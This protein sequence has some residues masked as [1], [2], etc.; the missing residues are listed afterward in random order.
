MQIAVQLR[1]ETRDD[2]AAML[3]GA[4]ILGNQCARK[5]DAGTTAFNAQRERRRHSLRER[6]F[7][8]AVQHSFGLFMNNRVSGILTGRAG[9]VSDH[10]RQVGNGDARK[11]APDKA[12]AGS[13][14]PLHACCP[15]ILWIKV[16]IL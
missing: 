10:V 6:I 7:L 11:P 4:V 12:S 8:A 5:F 3:A 13:G 15:Q 14:Y 9:P 1:Q 2:L 16:C